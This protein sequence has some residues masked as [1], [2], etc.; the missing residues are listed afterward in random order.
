MKEVVKAKDEV[1]GVKMK[2]KADETL[3]EV[4]EVMLDKNTGNVAYAV[5]ESGSFLG[6]GGK[7]F[8]IP[9]KAFHYDPEEECFILNVDKE[10]LKNAPGF[11]K[12][13][14][15]NMADRSWGDSVYEYYNTPRYWD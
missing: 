3:G 1:I 11:D 2:N 12:D 7:L 8:A 10:K 4:C 6:L 15:P 14:W 9:W 13:H 5:L